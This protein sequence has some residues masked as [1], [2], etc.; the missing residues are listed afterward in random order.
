MTK[1]LGF[2]RQI[3]KECLDIIWNY[4]RSKNTR[5]IRDNKA[6]HAVDLPGKD[7]RRRLDSL[8]QNVV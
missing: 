7:A 3:K 5:E 4:C 6:I 1:M 2:D 8:S